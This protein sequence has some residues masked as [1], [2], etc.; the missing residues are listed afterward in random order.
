MFK[1]RQNIDRLVSSV[2]VLVARNSKDSD[3]PESSVFV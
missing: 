3:K 2:F 1:D